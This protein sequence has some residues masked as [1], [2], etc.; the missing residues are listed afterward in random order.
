[1]KKINWKK[2]AKTTLT[3]VLVLSMVVTNG[4]FVEAKKMT[5]QESVYVNVG[6]S[7][8]VSEVT[9]SDQLQNSSEKSGAIDDKSQLKDIKNI[10]GDETF[11]QNGES[12]TW[13]ATGK[14]IFYQGSTDKEL[15]VGMKISYK[16]DGKEIDAADLPGKS[17]KVE[18]HVVYENKSKETK[19]VRGKKVEIYTPFVMVTGIVLSNEHF[20]NVEI[21]HG[22]VI[23][24]GSNNIVIGMGLPGFSESLDI[25]EADAEHISSDFTVKADVTDFQMENTYTYASPSL[26]NE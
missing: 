8:T 23:N 4:S 15:P 24:E 12:L 6:A 19:N 17:G 3:G 11:S 2:T 25:D 21:D 13:N 5:K 10:K 14:D 20:N 1:M 16:L 26:L 9:V 7:G 22:R 18:I